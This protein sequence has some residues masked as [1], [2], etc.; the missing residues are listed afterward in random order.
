MKKGTHT[1]A[2]QVQYED[3]A[4]RILKEIQPFFYFRASVGETEIP[5][6]WR[7]QRLNGYTSQLRRINPQLGW[8]EW[9]DTRQLQPDWQMPQYDD[10]AWGTPVYV[11]RPL[12]DFRP[13]RI[14]PVKNRLIE[15]KVIGS[16]ELTET[17]GYPGDNPGASFYLRDLVA[18]KHPAQGVWRRYD[19]GRIRLSRPAMVLDLPAGAVVE[20]AYSE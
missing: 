15:P 20:I 16:G 18:D 4:T 8:I 7:C 1:V 12:G 14:A 10:T 19:L 11:E 5:V 6:V 2:V 17:F 9:V 13:S 3:V